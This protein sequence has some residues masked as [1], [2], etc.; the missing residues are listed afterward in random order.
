MLTECWVRLATILGILSEKT[1]HIY[2]YNECSTCMSSISLSSTNWVKPDNIFF[3]PFHATLHLPIN[4]KSSIVLHVWQLKG[5]EKII[6]I[7]SDKKKKKR[8]EEKRRRIKKKKSEGKVKTS[9]HSTNYQFHLLV[10]VPI[11]KGNQYSK[12]H[13]KLFNI[14]RRMSP[15]TCWFNLPIKEGST[16][17][18]V[19]NTNGGNTWRWNYMY[20]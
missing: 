6:I 15:V 14:H 9:A 8:K 20:L 7:K 12:P 16:S 11:G 17:H 2:L 4:D 1:D 18:Q 3:C 10:A 19:W 13:Q 5:L